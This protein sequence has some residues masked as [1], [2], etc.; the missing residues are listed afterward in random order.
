[1]HGYYCAII[2]AFT[3]VKKAATGCREPPRAINTAVF[4]RSR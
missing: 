1:M 3:G 2:L 4:P